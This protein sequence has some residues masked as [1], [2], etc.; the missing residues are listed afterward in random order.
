[1]A[2]A[3]ET[4]QHLRDALVSQQQLCGLLIED[5]NKLIDDLQEVRATPTTAPVQ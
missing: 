1:M 4:P 2:L 3:K 5:K